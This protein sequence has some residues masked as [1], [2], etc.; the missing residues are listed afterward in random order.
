MD[1][2]EFFKSLDF[3][4]YESKVLASLLRIK[5]G[6]TKQINFDSGVPQ[7][8]IYRVLDKFHNS[9]LVEIIPGKLK[10]YK[11]I[12]LKVFVHQ[13]LKEKGNKLKETKRISKELN[14]LKDPDETNLFSIIKSQKAIMNKLAE[15]N[16]KAKKEIFGVQRNWKVWGSGLREIQNAVKRGVDVKFIGIVDSE[17]KK[18]VL[19]WKKTGAKIKIYNKKFGHYPLRFS[20]FDSKGARVTIGK[21]E[22]TKPENYITVWTKSKPLINILRKQ[23]LDMWKECEKF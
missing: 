2:L 13:K 9:G 18:R 8:K 5:I 22:I 19:E 21:P 11:L 1:K 10:K 17:T 15:N 7:N 3:T 23:F 14:N 20:I 16:S 12:N 4:E 6:T